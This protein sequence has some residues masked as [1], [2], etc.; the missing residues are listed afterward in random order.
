MVS[1]LILPERWIYQAR[2][3][4]LHGGAK[5]I[6]TPTANMMADGMTKVVDK[7]KFFLCRNFYMNIF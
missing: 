3:Y 6:L 1:T 5:F 4:Q 7:S 2:D